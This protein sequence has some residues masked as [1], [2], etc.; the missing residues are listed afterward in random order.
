MLVSWDLSG[1]EDSSWAL[2]SLPETAVRGQERSQQQGPG[3]HSGDSH[4]DSGCSGYCFNWQVALSLALL[5]CGEVRTLHIGGESEGERRSGSGERES[6]RQPNPN[7][8]THS[9]S[10][11]PI[12]G[13]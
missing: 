2:V 7:Y 11:A 5:N 9:F 8:L 6:H 1:L 12:G 3:L 4:R 13:S 10:T